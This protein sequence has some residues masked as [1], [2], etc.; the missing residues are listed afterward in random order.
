LDGG[1]SEGF[2]DGRIP[3]KDQAMSQPTALLTPEDLWQR[4]QF[5]DR[6]ELNRARRNL[7]LSPVKGMGFIIGGM[8]ALALVS[9]LTRH[10]VIQT[11]YGPIPMPQ[12][13]VLLTMV[14]MLAFGA[15]LIIIK[16]LLPVVCWWA[17]ITFRSP[18]NALISGT[19][20]RSHPLVLH[21][22]LCA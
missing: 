1:E 12:M 8:L 21:M 9:H 6:D 17:R 15:Y 4:I 14:G 11:R 7:W 16:T 22:S 3:I 18:K 19:L 2:K 10:I 5:Q 20:H 13:I